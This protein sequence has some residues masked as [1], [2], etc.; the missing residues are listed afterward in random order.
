MP[1]VDKGCVTHHYACDC[2]EEMH[3][4]E[5]KKLKEALYDLIQKGDRLG[6]TTH[7]P[8]HCGEYLA[9]CP[10]ISV[11]IVKDFLETKKRAQETIENIAGETNA[12]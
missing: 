8:R 6:L 4:Q 10:Q 9:V 1:F 11:N 3:K 12:T 5:I 2:R 7:N